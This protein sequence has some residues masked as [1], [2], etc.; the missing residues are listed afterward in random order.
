[1]ITKYGLRDVALEYVVSGENNIVCA[2]EADINLLLRNT[3]IDTIRHAA[4]ELSLE[5]TPVDTI[6]WTGTLAF[7]EETTLTFSSSLND[8]ANSFS[9]KADSL[10]YVFTDEVPAN[11]QIAWTLNAQPEG[12]PVFLNF[13]TDN[14]PQESTWKLFDEDNVVIASGGPFSTSQNTYM[15]EF[16]LDPEACYKFTVYDA[17]GDGMSAQGVQGD[18]E[19]FNQDGDLIADLSRPN[20]GSQ[21][22]SNFCLTA[23]CLFELQVGVEHESA[24]G[25]GDGVA[26]A[27]T[28]NSLG[29]ITY[30]IDGG[31]TFQASSSFLNL[32]AG[33][34]NLIAKDGAGCLDTSTFEI[35]SCTLQTLITTVPA[36]GGDVGEIHITVTGGF[37]PVTYSLQEGPFVTDSVFTN[38]EPGDYIVTVKDSLGCTSQDTVTVSTSVGT[39]SL[40]GDYFIRIS[41]N[42]G[43]GLYQVEASFNS[44]YIFI[45]YTLLNAAGQPLY[46]GTIVRY[47]DRY[48]GEISIRA[49]PAGVYYAAFRLDSKIAVSRIIKL[50]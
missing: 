21:T 50:E 37:G 39:S 17:F 18:Y 47:N 27:E 42:P 25:A 2:D 24:P 13:T 9:I 14:F 34:Y 46:D 8:G 48:R 45:P 23:Q 33:I 31:N 49:Y 3:G 26:I 35:L 1:M 29:N 40:N 30:S 16:C 28:A 22:S 12:Q 4:F 36:I 43:K 10:N 5:S 11:S 44:E 15:T 32:D 19:I 41:P 6:T 7:G 20:F 38:L